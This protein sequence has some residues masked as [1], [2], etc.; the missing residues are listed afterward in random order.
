MASSEGK[1]CDSLIS[2]KMLTS[3]E[4][5]LWRSDHCASIMGSAEDSGPESEA[6]F[7][8]LVLYSKG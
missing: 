7:N 2:V 6:A 5:N 1:V 3:G 8:A 4:G